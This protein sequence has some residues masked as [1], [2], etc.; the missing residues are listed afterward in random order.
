MFAIDDHFFGIFVF[1]LQQSI[2]QK[3][4]SLER[5]AIPAD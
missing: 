5:F 2:Q 4:D 3:L 1:G